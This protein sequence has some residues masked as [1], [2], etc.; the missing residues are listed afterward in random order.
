MYLVDTL[1][2][3]QTSQDQVDPWAHH[4]TKINLVSR[5]FWDA[6][7]CL[8]EAFKW[9]SFMAIHRY[10]PTRMPIF[11]NALPFLFYSTKQNLR[12]PEFKASTA[13]IGNPIPILMTL[14]PIIIWVLAP[15]WHGTHHKAVF[16]AWLILPSWILSHISV[17]VVKVHDMQ[18]GADN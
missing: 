15:R 9:Q 2:S 11:V 13:Q 5:S 6:E 10:K 8:S 12:H 17:V 4:R 18:E 14:Q 7:I 1:C 16:P 3:P